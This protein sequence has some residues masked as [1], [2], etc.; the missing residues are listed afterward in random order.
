MDYIERDIKSLNK[1]IA[2]EIAERS[3]SAE[4]DLKLWR[5]EGPRR[6]VIVLKAAAGGH[7][8]LKKLRPVAIALELLAAGVR[9]HFGAGQPAAA[10]GQPAANIALVTAD[11]FYVRALALVVTLRDDRLVKILCEALASISEGYAYPEAPDRADRLA[12]FN[13]AAYRLG[14]LLSG[15]NAASGDL[16]DEISKEIENAVFS[17]P[18]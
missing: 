2:R 18:A 13:V 8:D 14:R 7:Y 11:S 9:K 1:E 17:D 5:E 4:S 15:N 3:D 16:P 10:Y 6:A 12:A